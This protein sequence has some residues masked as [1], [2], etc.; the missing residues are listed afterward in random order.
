M[1]P[2]CH[3]L[4][5]SSLNS[6]LSTQ[7]SINQS[8]SFLSR[9]YKRTIPNFDVNC[10]PILSSYFFPP[11]FIGFPILLTRSQA[12]GELISLG[13][14]VFCLAQF[15][16]FLHG[17]LLS[18]LYESPRCS[19]E[20][21]GGVNRLSWSFLQLTQLDDRPRNFLAA[22]DKRLRGLPGTF[23]VLLWN[24]WGSFFLRHKYWFSR[25]PNT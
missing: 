10:L 8:V 9:I 14:L 13:E 18:K 6:A 5:G 3:C 11:P 2:P 16:G 15:L 22:R 1:N 4:H 17:I 24:F 21:G 7:I 12:T 20:G 23:G 19:L 25:I